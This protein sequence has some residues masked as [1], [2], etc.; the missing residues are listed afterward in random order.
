MSEDTD[1]SQQF[2][3]IMRSFAEKKEQDPQGNIYVSFA[4]P[5]TDDPDFLERVQQTGELFSDKKIQ[6]EFKK[7]QEPNAILK[8]TVTNLSKWTSKDKIGRIDISYIPTGV[9]VPF[10][11]G[12]QMKEGDTAYEL[13]KNL[14]DDYDGEIIVTLDK[15]GHI[16]TVSLPENDTK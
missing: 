15:K 8:G 9:D 12:F 6:K 2:E 14:P 7:T 1:A 4:P 3:D 16:A 10:P 13:L 5:E 11:I